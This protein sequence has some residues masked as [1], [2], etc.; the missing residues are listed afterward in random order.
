MK[1]GTIREEGSVEDLLR[2]VPAKQIAVVETDDEP[3]VIDRA[4]ALGWG[5]RRYAG[6][7]GLLLPR[8]SSLREVVD[9]LDTAAVSSIALQKVSLEHAY[10]ELTSESGD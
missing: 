1:D 10:L 5:H 7:L 8:Q 2:F 6:K 3:A 4:S 9:T